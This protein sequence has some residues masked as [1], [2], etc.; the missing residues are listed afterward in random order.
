M[1]RRKTEL[2]IALN[3]FVLY[4]RT[5]SEDK[6]LISLKNCLDTNIYTPFIPHKAWPYVRKKVV[7]KEIKICFPGYVFIRSLKSANEALSE[8][9]SAIYRIKEAYYFL[10]YG[11]DKQDITLRE[12]ERIYIERLMNIEFC[13]DSSLGFIEGDCVKIISGALMGL[14]SVI[15]KINKQKRTATIDMEMFGNKR[16]VTLMLELLEKTSL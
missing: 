12:N 14:E 10:Y 11:S 8:I 7:Q 4:V 1:P 5:A 3:W 6:V 16:Q 9:Q 15:T 2:S 13:M